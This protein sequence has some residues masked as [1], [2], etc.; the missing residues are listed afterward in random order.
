MPQELK[1]ART[2]IESLFK[3]ADVTDWDISVEVCQ[4]VCEHKVAWRVLGSSRETGHFSNV[5]LRSAKKPKD[6]NSVCEDKIEIS[7]VGGIGLI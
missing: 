3:S 1:S 6:T 2:N 4:N 5:A 7:S